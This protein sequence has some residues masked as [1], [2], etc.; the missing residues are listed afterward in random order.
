MIKSLFISGVQE[1]YTAEFIANLF[2]VDGIATV[3]RITLLPE[4]HLDDT[5][6]PEKKYF[7]AYIEIL[8]W[9][10]SLKIRFMQENLCAGINK[11]LLT[12]DGFHF[13][14][15]KINQRPYICYQP[16]NKLYTTI[17]TSYIEHDIILQP[18]LLNYVYTPYT[19]VM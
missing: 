5:M 13:W 14:E 1:E 17:F 18:Y 16:I 15:I 8:H 4:D 6:D 11:T 7:K 2:Y 10:D 3:S 9:H 12:Y 19:L